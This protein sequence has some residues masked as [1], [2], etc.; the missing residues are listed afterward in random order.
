MT[1]GSPS[2]QCP[3]AASRVTTSR[4]CAAASSVSSSS[5]PVR[6][7][8]SGSVHDDVP[9]PSAATNEYGRPGTRCPAFFPRPFTWQNSRSGLV[10]ASGRSH[11]VTSAASRIRPSAQGGSGSPA[12]VVRSRANS[13]RPAF[14][15]SYSAP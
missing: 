6:T 5:G 1:G 11:A 7:A 8:S 9:G 3:A 14:S 13:A 12:T 2:F 15:P 4:S 10:P